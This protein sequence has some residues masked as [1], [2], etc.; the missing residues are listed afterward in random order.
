MQHCLLRHPP[1]SR[2]PPILLMI[3][4]FPLICA[5]DSVFPSVSCLPHSISTKHGLTSSASSLPSSATPADWCSFPSPSEEPYLPGQPGENLWVYSPLSPAATKIFLWGAGAFDP[6]LLPWVWL[7]FLVSLMLLCG[8]AFC[9]FSL[10]FLHLLFFPSACCLRVRSS[11]QT[12]INIIK[13]I[14]CI[15]SNYPLT[16]IQ[17]VKFFGWWPPSSRTKM[18]SVLTFLV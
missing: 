13:I 5:L 7:V 12:D 18:L 8:P 1:S 10:F 3:S 14:N 4:S 15:S 2:F 11:E 16:L 17:Q 9:F 6:S